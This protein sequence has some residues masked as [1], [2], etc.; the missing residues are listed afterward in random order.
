MTKYKI[1]VFLLLFVNSIAVG[2]SNTHRVKKGET[3]FSIAKKYK[4]SE[5]AL[6]KLNPSI[7]GKTLHINTILKLQEDKKE[8]TVEIVANEGFH[9][10][11]RGESF[12]IIS[13][14]YNITVE[15]LSE[16]NPKVKPKKLKAG[17]LLKILPLQ[18]E[19]ATQETTLALET[20]PNQNEGSKRLEHIIQ[21]K[22]TKYGVSKIYGISI[23]TLESLNP[24]IKSNFPVGQ[25]LIIQTGE[26][27]PQNPAIN[28]EETKLATIPV[29]LLEKADFLI[30]KASEHIGTR[31]RSGGTTPN[32]FDCSGLM[33][34]TFQAIDLTL[35]RTSSDQA[36]YG[37]IIDRNQAQKGDL[38]FFA[39]GRK[40]SRISHVGMITEV[41]G[42]EIKFIHSSTSSGVIVSSLNESY[43]AT[44]FKQ[45]NRVL[46]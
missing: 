12:F 5:A 6:Y 40:K 11:K 21:P 35:P 34:S 37:Y 22:E 29:N 43:Y 17:T 23:E 16:L 24:E 25:K 14:Q 32:G 10:V 39:T 26:N 31:Y 33:F 20:A 1:I 19:E 2:Q 3:I 4:L 28:Q 27:A 30:E 38:I 36:N 45:I 13:K 41:S 8:S 15:Q 9:K 18:S 46:N 42:D 44:R 7:K